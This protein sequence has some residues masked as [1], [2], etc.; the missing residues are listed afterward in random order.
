M[1][2]TGRWLCG[3]LVVGVA[4]SAFATNLRDSY[5]TMNFHAGAREGAAAVLADPQSTEL[6]A[7]Y[8]ANL[9]RVDAEAAIRAARLLRYAHPDNA[10]S[11]FAMTA[12]Q[13][14][15]D[16]EH[17]QAAESAEKMIALYKG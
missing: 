4:A 16:T 11:W 5:R 14:R 8:I 17:E 7:W 9:S 1:H 15:D 3:L 12:A 13:L 6:R 2:I 10:W